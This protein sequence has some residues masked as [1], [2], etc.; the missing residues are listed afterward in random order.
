MAAVPASVFGSA[1]NEP[2]PSPPNRYVY[3][4]VIG[5]PVGLQAS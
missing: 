5:P 3:V 2:S 1:A 4:Y